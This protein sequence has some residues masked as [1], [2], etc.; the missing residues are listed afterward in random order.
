MLGARASG[1]MGHAPL[2]I[3]LEVAEEA[4]LPVMCQLDWPPQSP[5]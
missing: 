1:S 4:C 5:V 2:D 3:A